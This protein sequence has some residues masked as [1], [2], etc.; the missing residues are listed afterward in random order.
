MN[1]G[2]ASK[3]AIAAFGSA[4]GDQIGS[5]PIALGQKHC[6]TR[7]GVSRNHAQVDATN[8]ERR[9]STKQSKIQP[10]FALTIVQPTWAGWPENNFLRQSPDRSRHNTIEK[11][12]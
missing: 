6:K 10:G 3:R 11:T 9:P 5:T 7:D 8:R 4:L 12:T 2:T 1:C